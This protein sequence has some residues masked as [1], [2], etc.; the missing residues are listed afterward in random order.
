MQKTKVAIQRLD[1]GANHMS[2]QMEIT[3]VSIKLHHCPPT[4][5]RS[6]N[7][8]YLEGFLGCKI[9]MAVIKDKVSW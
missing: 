7:Y 8:D 1:V 4:G 5:L 9:Y 6:P 2:I 3:W